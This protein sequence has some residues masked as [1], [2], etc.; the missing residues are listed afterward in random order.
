MSDLISRKEAIKAV[1]FYETFYDP[2]PRVIEALEDLPSVQPEI[3][4]CKDCKW[5][6]KEE[7]YALGCCHAI[8]HES[9]ITRQTEMSYE[10]AWALTCVDNAPT[11]QPQKWVPCSEM[12]PEDYVR[13]LTTNSKIGAWEVDINS[14]NVAGWIYSSD[15]VAWMP[16]PDPYKEDKT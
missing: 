16:L 11:I 15:P 10:D 2:Y 14:R 3:I 4:R 9:I 8:K 13:V 1:K 6:D 7:D 5:W 12:L